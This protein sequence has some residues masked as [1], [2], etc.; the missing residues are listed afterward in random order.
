MILYCT[1]TY[2]IFLGILL[3]EHKHLEDCNKN[4]LICFILSPIVV[5]IIAGMS[6]NK[7]YDEK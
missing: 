5:P 4:D 1:I 6:I 2:L 3:N 7:K